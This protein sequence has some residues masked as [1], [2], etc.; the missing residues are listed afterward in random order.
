M[1]STTQSNWT[2]FKDG[3]SWILTEGRATG[4]LCTAELRKIAGLGVNIVQV[5]SDAKCYLK[6]IFNALEAFRT[7]RDSEG[8]RLQQNAADS[9]ELLEFGVSTGQD[10]PLDA[11]GD[12]PLATAVTSELLAHTEALQ[13]LFQGEHPIMVPIRPTDKYKL[14]FF[15]GDASREGF[16]GSTQYPDRLV[17]SREGL[18]DPEFS[19]G[20]SNLREAQNQVNHLI[21][22]I[23]AGFHDGCEVWA[24]TDNSVWSAV[25]NKGLSSARHLFYLVLVLK[26]EARKNEVYLHCFHI[27]GERMIA[28]GVDG[29]SR[30]NYDAGISLGIDI[31]Q[32]LPMNLSAWDVAGGGFGGLVQKLDG[33]GLCAAADP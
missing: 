23:R 25:W 31:H 32:F 12:Y 29:L 30:G 19:E 6:G 18:W 14:R 17:S 28:S 21:A 33:E 15:V 3:L 4:S 9:A 1:M 22:K 2:R 5:Y 26:Q 16:G 7:D 10:S 20:G 13:V 24:A 11:Q 8:W 27:S